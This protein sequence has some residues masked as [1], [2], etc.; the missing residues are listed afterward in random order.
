MR[1][2]I[3]I[4]LD[5]LSASVGWV[6]IPRSGAGTALVG[7]AVPSASSTMLWLVMVVVMRIMMVGIMPAPSVRL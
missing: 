4:R 5:V 6:V 2:H 3:R 7:D 1:M